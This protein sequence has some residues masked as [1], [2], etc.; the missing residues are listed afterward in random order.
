MVTLEHSIISELVKKHTCSNFTLHTGLIF[1]R[2]N[3]HGHLF[4]SKL[5]TRTKKRNSFTVAYCLDDVVMFGQIDY[6]LCVSVC[7]SQYIYAYITQYVQQCTNQSHF[8]ISNNALDYGTRRIIPVHVG[9][10][11]LVDVNCVLCKCVCVSVMT[12]FVRL[13]IE[14]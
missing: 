11:I 6:F 4:Y 10:K 13:V 12:M 5:Y 14:H 7:G 1:Q 2:C 3:I 8:G 9:D